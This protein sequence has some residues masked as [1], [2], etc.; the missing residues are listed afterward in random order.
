MKNLSFR[1]ACFN[2]CRASL[3]FVITTGACGKKMDTDQSQGAVC[4]Q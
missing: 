1:S 3:A 4:T 2:R